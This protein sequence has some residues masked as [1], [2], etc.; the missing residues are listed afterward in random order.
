MEHMHADGTF[1]SHSHPGEMNR[2]E[3]VQEAEKMLEYMIHHNAS[4]LKELDDLAEYLYD[5]GHI[6]EHDRLHEA[7]R[8]YEE[9][10]AILEEVKD[11]LK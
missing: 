6:E 9:G 5:Q 2:L 8:K 10:N 3:S 7:A 1:H 11:G 4:H